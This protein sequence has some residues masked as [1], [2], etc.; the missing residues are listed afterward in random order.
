ML[1]GVVAVMSPDDNHRRRSRAD[2]MLARG[3]E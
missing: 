2:D 1:H 3:G